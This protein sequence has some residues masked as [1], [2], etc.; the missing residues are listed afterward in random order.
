MNTVFTPE[1]I[2]VLIGQ[3]AAHFGLEPGVLSGTRRDREAVYARD[4]AIW[5]AF[6]FGASCA[7]IGE[8]MNR[9]K[10]SIKQAIDKVERRSAKDGDL[11]SDLHTLKSSLPGMNTADITVCSTGYEQEAAA[12]ARA[13][14][15]FQVVRHTPQQ[16][17]ALHRLL[18]AAF[19]LSVAYT[20]YHSGEPVNG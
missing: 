12:V 14:S 17:D 1:H 3:T 16:G 18:D 15:A 4:C 11:V 2:D 6:Q 10:L 7:D 5:L 20:E 13:Y 19:K 8:A 9:D